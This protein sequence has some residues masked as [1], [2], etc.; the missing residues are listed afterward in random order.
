MKKLLHVT[1]IMIM[2]LITMAQLQNLDF[3]NWDEPMLWDRNNP[4]GWTCYNR[5][6]G[7]PDAQFNDHFVQPVETLSQNLKYGLRLMTYYNYM[8]D[9]ALQIAPI[10]YKPS[11]LTG[12]Y[13][14]EDNMIL[15]GND[16]IVDTAQ[17]VVLL[18]KWNRSLLKQDTIGF[19]FFST[20]KITFGY[21]A[22]QVDIQY[23]STDMPD[24]ITVYLDP[25]II[26]RDPER[27][28]QT[29][30]GGGTSTFTLDNL[31]LVNSGTTGIRETSPMYD[32]K[33]YPNP[34]Q[35]E[36]NIGAI[37]GEGVITDLAG[38]QMALFN[39]ESHQSIDISELQQGYY[40][41]KITNKNG[42]YRSEILKQ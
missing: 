33:P 31:S 41:I 28:F 24:S 35:G 11:A 9:A 5:W 15:D 22:F 30:A 19:G 29:N 4:T 27:L 40:I 36:L 21:A 23:V 1:L 32:L 37:S 42:I 7:F 8:K 3:E 6:F 26:G 39:I 25:S 34:T 13:K 12:F 10:D 14:Y 38:K 17:V 2:P 18:T 16:W 20:H